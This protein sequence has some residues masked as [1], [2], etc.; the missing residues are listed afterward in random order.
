MP[1]PTAS[2]CG[3]ARSSSLAISSPRLSYSRGFRRGSRA[4]LAAHRS[5]PPCSTTTPGTGPPTS[6][7]CAVAS[8]GSSP[9]RSSIISAGVRC[10]DGGSR[11]ALFSTTP[12]EPP[13]ASWLSSSTTLRWNT[14]PSSGSPAAGTATNSS[15]ARSCLYASP[16]LI[17]WK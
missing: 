6:S 10:S 3:V 8:V 4:A 15:P 16:R 7:V 17:C 1:S 9:S 11:S 5:S 2:P 13:S 12:S 14:L